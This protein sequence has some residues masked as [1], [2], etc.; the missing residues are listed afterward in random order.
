MPDHPTPAPAPAPTPRPRRRRRL[1]IFLVVVL[2][3][4]LLVATAYHFLSD[5]RRLAAVIATGVSIVTR[6]QVHIDRVEFSL[7]APIAIE[8]FTLRVPDMPGTDNQL[9]SATR[10]LIEHDP[11]A[12]LR[13]SFKPLTVSFE[14]PVLYITED[15]DRRKFNFQLLMDRQ[16]SESSPPPKHWPQIYLGQAQAVFGRVIDGKYE[17]FKTIDLT[18]NMMPDPDAAGQYRITL[19]HQNAD[20]S[21][22]AALTSHFDPARR[23][24]S[25]RLEHFD[26]QSPLFNLLPARV[27]QWW[28]R[29]EPAGTV[30]PITF[31]YDPD[32]AVGF[33]ASLAVDDFSLSLPYGETASRMTHVHGS[34]DLRGET[35]HL[36]HLHGRIEDVAYVINGQVHGFSADA[37]FDFQ[38]NVAGGIPDQPRFLYA[39]PKTAQTQF[40]RFMPS[41][42]FDADIH[43]SRTPAQTVADASTPPAATRPAEKIN[44][45]GSVRFSKAKLRYF[46]FPYP[47][48][49]L[50]GT[51]KLSNKSVDLVD[52]VGNG[53]TGARIRMTG[54]VFPPGEGAAVD[55]LIHADDLPLDDHVYTALPDKEKP[56]YLMFLHPPSHKQLLD[57]GVV[58]SEQTSLAATEPSDSPSTQPSATQPT[59]APRSWAAPIFDLDG[60]VDADFH[61]LR[62]F[63]DD[64]RIRV[65]STLHAKNTPVLFKHWPY[66][67]RAIGGSVVIAPGLVTIR[68]GVFEGLTG[69]VIHIDGQVQLARRDPPQV[70][71]PDLRITAENVPLDQL[72]LASIPYPQDRWLRD[73]HAAATLHGEGRIFR[74][75]TR[76]MDYAIDLEPSGG[77]FKPYDGRYL[78]SDVQGRL[79]LRPG[80]LT[81]QSLQGRHNGSSF[82]VDGVTAWTDGRPDITLNLHADALRFEEPVLDL[83]P[84][85]LALY[86]RLQTLFEQH[87]P[88]GLFDLEVEYNDHGAD[89]AGYVLRLSPKNLAFDLRGQRVELTNMHGQLVVNPD[90][91]WFKPLTADISTGSI[92]ANA[93][94]RVAPRTDLDMTLDVRADRIDPVV[95]AFLPDGVLAAIDGMSLQGAFTVDDARLR[96][97]PYAKGDPTLSFQGP[98]NFSNASADLGFRITR[99][100]GALDVDAASFSGEPLPRLNLSLTAPTLRA[101]DRLVENARATLHSDT[102]HNILVIDKF[103]GACY[104]G[105]ILGS[106][107]IDM[108][109]PLSYEL[110]LVLQDV[111]HEPFVDLT[112]EDAWLADHPSEPDVDGGVSE[113]HPGTAVLSINMNLDGVIGRPET[114]HG[115]GKLM[116]RDAHL[117][118]TPLAMAMLH[119]VNLNFPASKAFDRAGAEFLIDGDL[120]RI[121]SLSIES[122]SV[123]LVGS[124][125][126]RYSDRALDLR[127]YSR[128]P[129]GLKIEPLTSVFNMI[130]DELLTIRVTGTLDQPQTSTSTLSGIGSSLNEIFGPPQKNRKSPLVGTN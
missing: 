13:L 17:A 25:A 50:R 77:S 78:I 68:D 45:E 111:A 114:R 47:L 61:I 48:Q 106:G 12:L 55:V 7:K 79:L 126:M 116:V 122:P 72:L 52:V 36:N 5:P 56:D 76:E 86:D 29:L 2:I 91:L 100:Q 15:L 33:Y 39:L 87:K 101:M 105:V 117:F 49:D 24:I 59:H 125:V 57:R 42:L 35:I 46:R 53:P 130:K 113:R 65:T 23:S 104:G 92:A 93:V 119:I 26:L 43:L 83:V 19:L 84:P 85:Q 82:S 16:Q 124:G 58:R 98:I 64:A 20:G 102:Q 27:R 34:F 73:L 14:R 128:N 40:Y 120:V 44:Y 97:R 6:A 4:T 60:K 11:W 54:S 28:E 21:P 127:M 74:S 18:G 63:G 3:L 10:I 9:F 112:Q 118:K 41:G 32:P 129:A 67:V 30:S 71:T 62:D 70:L 31:G 89:A 38:V 115:R 123:E 109:P 51:I 88:A 108:K 81:I 103:I 99:L 69:G 110:S 8:G 37:P 22:G 80:S 107:A 94:L 75:D 1:R 96:W 90:S 66:P 121:D 95:R